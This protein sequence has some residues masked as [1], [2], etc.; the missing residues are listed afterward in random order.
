MTVLPPVNWADTARQAAFERWFEAIAPRHGLDAR[1]LQPASA[2]ASFRRY[3]R[4]L[5]AARLNKSP[6]SP[7]H[8][9]QTLGAPPA[10]EPPAPG[11]AERTV[12]HLTRIVNALLAP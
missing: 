8:A 10:A 1:T 2:D 7:P 6:G 11:R 12:S 3:L 9:A 5:A 4:V